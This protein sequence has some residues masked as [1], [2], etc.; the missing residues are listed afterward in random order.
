MRITRKRTVDNDEISVNRKNIA[1]ESAKS[2]L[3]LKNLEQVLLAAYVSV[4]HFI[5]S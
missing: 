4:M 2:G 5:L 1:V 3:D